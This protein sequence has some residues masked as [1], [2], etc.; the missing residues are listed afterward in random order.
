ML[1]VGITSWLSLKYQRDLPV[2]GCPVDTPASISEASTLMDVLWESLLL[3]AGEKV[4]L[5]NLSIEVILDSGDG[6]G[7]THGLS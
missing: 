6:P 1:V 3:Q 2:V 4:R 5:Q 7:S